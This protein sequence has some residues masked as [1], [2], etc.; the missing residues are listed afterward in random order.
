MVCGAAKCYSLV[1]L[2][3][4]VTLAP[5][6]MLVRC[7][8]LQVDLPLV[9]VPMCL[10]QLRQRTQGYPPSGWIPLLSWTFAVQKQLLP[11]MLCLIVVEFLRG[12]V[13]VLL[14]LVAVCP[15]LGVVD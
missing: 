2:A 10:V 14:E 5:G 13:C 1:T 3:R 15:G 9:W 7:A 4:L 8:L 11:Y 6:R 12:L